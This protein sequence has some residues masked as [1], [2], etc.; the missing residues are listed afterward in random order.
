MRRDD[1]LLGRVFARFGERLA[2]RRD[3]EPFPYAAAGPS[4]IG[5]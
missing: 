1:R 2:A 4:S 3:S 5:R